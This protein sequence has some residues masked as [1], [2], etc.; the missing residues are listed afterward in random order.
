[1]E[2][3]IL[4]IDELLASK[5]IPIIWAPKDYFENGNYIAPCEE[6]PNGAIVVKLGMNSYETR[7]TKIHESHHLLKGVQLLTLTSPLVHYGNEF[8]A[9]CAIIQEATPSFIEENE[10]SLQHATAARLCE[11]LD[12]N[13]NEYC[14]VAEDEIKH[15][16][17][18]K[19]GILPAFRFW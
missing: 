16:V 18:D 17:R 8:N 7:W 3:E 9:N 4:N 13:Y 12:L 15:V 5:N 11:R 19:Y 6:L 1:M 2:D 10:N 14:Q